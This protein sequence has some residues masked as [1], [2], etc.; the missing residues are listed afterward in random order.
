MGP[1]KSWAAASTFFQYLVQEAPHICAYS[2]SVQYNG[3]WQS[4][5]LLTPSAICDTQPLCAAR[6]H[7]G[8]RCVHFKLTRQIQHFSTLVFFLLIDEDLASVRPTSVI[9]SS[10]RAVKPYASCR[11]AVSSHPAPFSG[12]R[13]ESILLLE[14]EALP[15]L[16]G[17]RSRSIIPIIRYL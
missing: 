17:Y 11:D 6:V 8:M 16:V 7:N 2:R 12:Y 3:L 9:G 10:A 5:G 13:I 4:L 1:Q 15:S 14:F